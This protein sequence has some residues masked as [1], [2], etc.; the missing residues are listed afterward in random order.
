MFL[1][2]HARATVTRRVE[3][4]EMR[5]RAMIGT[6][7]RRLWAKRSSGHRAAPAL[8][9]FFFFAVD[10]FLDAFVVLRATVTPLSWSS[11]SSSL[12][13][14]SSSTPSVHVFSHVNVPS[15]VVDTSTPSPYS[16]VNHLANSEA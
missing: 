11:S 4:S 16:H 6:A 1:G 8:F 10:F 3:S 12:S 9:Y 5:A 14:S 15:A 2:E 7:L 13:S